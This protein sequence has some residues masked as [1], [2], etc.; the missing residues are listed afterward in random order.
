IW[1]NQAG[2][3]MAGL[4]TVTDC[5]G[6]S[7]KARTG[8]LELAGLVTYYREIMEDTA[9]SGIIDSLVR[10]IDYYAYLDDGTIQGESRQENVRELLSVAKA[11][12][13]VGLEGF[14]EEVSLISELDN[15]DGSSNAV[16]L[17]TLH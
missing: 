9:V 4:E 3:L 7:A 2:S 1:A 17:M 11:Y 15:L 13:D 12:Q 8:L 6:L 5:P 10:R 16:T 14:L